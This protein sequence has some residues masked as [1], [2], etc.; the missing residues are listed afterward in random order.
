MNIFITGYGGFIGRSLALTL[1]KNEHNVV[2]ITANKA[3]KKSSGIEIVHVDW[4]SK[5]SIKDSVKDGADILI[6]AAGCD[7]TTC[8]AN[9]GEA[10]WFHG[11]A[12]EDLMHAASSSKIK[13]IIYISTVHVYGSPLQGVL[14]EKSPAINQH[15]YAACHL[16]SEKIVLQWASSF[17]NGVD[18]VRATNLYGEIDAENSVVSN[19][20]VE[21]FCRDAINT[22]KIQLNSN[23]NEVRDFLDIKS[24][25]GILMN[26]VLL[27]KSKNG[28]IINL[29]SGGSVSIIELASLVSN[30]VNSSIGAEVKILLG[31]KIYKKMKP[32][33]I[34]NTNYFYDRPDYLTELSRNIKKICSNAKK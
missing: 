32:L 30:I 24:F 25:C 29:C 7:A 15:P 10:T 22:G 13:K 8:L 34:R 12:V 14:T 11:P 18:I 1:S 17:T 20:L 2:G 9:H 6:H 3:L 5:S 33:L 28:S 19:G 4:S 16:M 31:K 23:G 27:K 26:D 21:T